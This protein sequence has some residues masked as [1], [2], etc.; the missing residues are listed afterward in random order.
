MFRRHAVVNERAQ[1]SI[2]FCFLPHLHHFLSAVLILPLPLQHLFLLR[3]DLRTV[4]KLLKT[5]TNKKGNHPNKKKR[6]ILAVPP[7]AQCPA[8]GPDLWAGGD[9]QRRCSWWS[10][11]T[12]SS[13]TLRCLWVTTSPCAASR[14]EQRGG[15]GKETS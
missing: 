8:S 14:N 10:W 5:K 9:S 13:W 7:P 15:K 2:R 12:A 11:C 4:E 6:D 1:N 3:D